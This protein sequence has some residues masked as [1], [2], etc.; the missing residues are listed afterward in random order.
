MVAFY[1]VGLRFKKN[2]VKMRINHWFSNVNTKL[3]IHKKYELFDEGT[4]NLIFESR[5][6]KF[7]PT[8]LYSILYK[9]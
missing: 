2:T 4:I 9:F 6:V 5:S 8:N 3:G 1:N 7:G